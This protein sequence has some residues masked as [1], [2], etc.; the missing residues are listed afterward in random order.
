MLKEEVPV[1]F[2]VPFFNFCVEGCE[3][4]VAFLGPTVV[5]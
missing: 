2:I 1:L 3:Y 4:T 5:Y